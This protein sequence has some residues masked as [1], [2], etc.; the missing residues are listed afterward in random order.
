MRAKTQTEFAVAWIK[1]VDALIGCF[2]RDEDVTEFKHL[3]G[4]LKQLIMRK[5]MDLPFPRGDAEEWAE[6]VEDSLKHEVTGEHENVF[7]HN[8]RYWSS[9]MRNR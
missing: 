7:V 6:L 8:E 1:S 5:A 9:E 3:Q 4:H 2:P